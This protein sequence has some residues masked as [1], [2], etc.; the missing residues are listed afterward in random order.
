[1]P[2]LSTYTNGAVYAVNASAK[3]RRS[4]TASMG[5]LSTGIRTLNGNDPAGQAVASNITTQAR[6]ANVAARNAEDG[7]SVLQAA[8][9]VL[10]ELA[11]TSTVDTSINLNGTTNLGDKLENLLSKVVR[12]SVE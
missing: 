2:S 12:I 5:R 6:S 11:T 7:I 9:G 3:A 4:L 10:L 8:E 1:M